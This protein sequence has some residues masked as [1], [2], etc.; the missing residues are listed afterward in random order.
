[1]RS[2]I[3]EFSYTHLLMDLIY[4]CHV[5]IYKV[6]FYVSMPLLYIYICTYV[7]NDAF[8]QRDKMNISRSGHMLIRT[9]ILNIYEV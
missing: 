6:F 3:T 2:E 5:N 9:S 1:M 7:E 8:M 4:F